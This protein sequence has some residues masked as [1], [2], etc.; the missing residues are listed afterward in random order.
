MSIYVYM[1]RCADESYYIGS[2]RGTLELRIAQHNDGTFGG[3]TFYRRP[4]TLLFHQEFDRI[5]D[6]IAVER[7]LKGRTRAKKE[8]LIAGDLETL[9]ELAHGPITL[10]K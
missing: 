10:H 9:H 8:A 6:A 5:T 7:Q 4:V 1:V 2:T 3:Y